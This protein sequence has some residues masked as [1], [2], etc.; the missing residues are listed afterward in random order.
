M[1]HVRTPGCTTCGG[2]SEP[3][4]SLISPVM[5]PPAAALPQSPVAAAAVAAAVPVVGALPNWYPNWYPSWPAGSPNPFP[6]PYPSPYP[7]FPR[8][9]PRPPRPNPN[10]NPNPNPGPSEPIPDPVPPD[11]NFPISLKLTRQSDGTYTLDAT[12]LSP[13]KCHFASA[14]RLGT[15]VGVNLPQDLIGVQLPMT[16]KS[17]CNGKSALTYTLRGLRLGGTTGKQGVTAQLILTPNPYLV[18]LATARI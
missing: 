18:N 7:T 2:S 11:S 5:V 1:A 16:V 4:R 15:L 9:I 3:P 17:P 6:T 10:P 13:D 14:A 8:P 12:V